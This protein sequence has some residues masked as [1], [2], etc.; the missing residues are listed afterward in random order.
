MD[1]RR[2]LILRTVARAGSL[3]AGARELGWTQPA[4]SQHLR[5]LEREAGC[6]LLLR[7]PGGV[8]PTEAGRL[9]LARADAIAG[10][11]HMAEEEIATLTQL[12]RGTVRLAAYP[13]A[14]ATLV[15]RAIAGLRHRYPDVDVT[16]TEAEPP[17]ALTLLAAGEVDLALVFA[18]G[19]AAPGLDS[20]LRWRPV[21]EEPVR[22]VLPAGHRYAEGPVRMGML[23][24]EP[25]IVGCPRCREHQV[26]L[27]REAGFEPDVRHTTDDYVVVQNLVAAR[28]GVS[29]LPQAAVTAYRNPDIVIRDGAQWGRRSCGVVYRDGADLVP[30]TAAFLGE[31]QVRHL[32]DGTKGQVDG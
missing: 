29:L 31:L 10:Q 32:A 17:Q 6:P 24:A 3:S 30:A 4:V 5:A 14:A 21:G 18:Y 19:G 13:S 11:L 1:V 22:L 28:L 20:G 27:C 15:P 26:R 25:W 9:L 23:A 12:R 7:G 16:L 2:L 8:E